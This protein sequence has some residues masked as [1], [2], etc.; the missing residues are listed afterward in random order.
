MSKE[1]LYK[2]NSHT[3]TNHAFCSFSDNLNRRFARVANQEQ[4]M[5]GIQY[6]PFPSTS[7]TFYRPAEQQS[8]PASP[9][10]PQPIHG[11]LRTP[12]NHQ[13]HWQE[14]RHRL[15]LQVRVMSKYL[16][17]QALKRKKLAL[18]LQTGLRKKRTS[19]LMRGPPNSVSYEEL[20]KEKK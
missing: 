6:W 5:N 18:S 19:F 17:R 7:A 3:L 4:P 9:A 16:L 13:F 10:G 20:H 2:G 14:A 1:K 12:R 8:L 11:P 15:S